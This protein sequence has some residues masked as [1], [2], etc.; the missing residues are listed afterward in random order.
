VF[1]SNSPGC[2]VR[3]TRPAPGGDG[4]TMCT[5]SR[6]PGVSSGAEAQRRSSTLV[7]RGPAP[8]M[9]MEWGSPAKAFLPGQ[10]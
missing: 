7:P 5:V 4:S 2:A 1:I 3:H 8:T 6:V 10:M 9:A